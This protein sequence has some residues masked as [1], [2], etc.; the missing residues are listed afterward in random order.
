MELLWWQADR[1]RIAFWPAEIMAQL[2]MLNKKE[3]PRY[4][5]DAASVVSAQ[6]PLRPRTQRLINA[7]GKLRFVEYGRRQLLN[8]L[9]GRI[10]E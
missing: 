6:L 3:A 10:Q 7:T 8:T 2:R 5:L 9:G 4:G 1:N